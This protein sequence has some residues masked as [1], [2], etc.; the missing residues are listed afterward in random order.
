MKVIRMTP[1][2]LRAWNA[3]AS[4]LVDDDGD[5]IRKL[6]RDEEKVLGAVKRKSETQRKTLEQTVTLTLDGKL[7]ELTVKCVFRQLGR[8]REEFRIETFVDGYHLVSGRDVIAAELLSV[9]GECQLRH[10]NG[11]IQKVI[12][13]P[14]K[15][16]PG[17]EQSNQLAPHPQ[18]CECV[19][20]GEPHPLVHHKHCP[21]NRVAPPEQ[22]APELTQ[23]EAIEEVPRPRLPSLAFTRSP[24]A[25]TRP[26]RNAP[27][28]PAPAIVNVPNPAPRPMASSQ[29][30]DPSSPH[31]CSH[32]CTSWATPKNQP[33]PEGSHHPFCPDA[34]AW[35][36]KVSRETPR[37]VV[38]LMTG[39][40]VRPAEDDEIAKASVAQQKT[41]VPVITLDDKPFAILREDELDLPEATVAAE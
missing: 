39:E 23:P 41:G 40:V 28:L 8:N 1:K 32:T 26:V 20:W 33:I 11:T 27:D 25:P 3:N 16:R 19:G 34:R 18:Y 37:Y 22:Q 14:T 29:N 4:H 13:D 36:A 7:K 5:I 38:D 31:T 12:R 15:Q 21:W 6:H 17:L 24:G 35:A 30:L 9:H 10:P 2:A